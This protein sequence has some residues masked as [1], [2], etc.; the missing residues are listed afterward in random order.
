[1]EWGQ[2]RYERVAAQLL[3]AAEGVV[4]RAAIDPAERVVN[5]GSGTGNSA[6]LSAWIPDGSDPPQQPHDLVR[7]R[8]PQRQDGRDVGGK[9]R[10]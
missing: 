4:K 7:L 8:H 6:L 5:V 2:G 3:P 10:E 9:P 1:M